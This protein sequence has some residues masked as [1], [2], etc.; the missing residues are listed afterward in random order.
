MNDKPI[1]IPLSL[2]QPHPQNPRLVARMFDGK[3]TARGRDVRREGGV[4]GRNH[5]R[6]LRRKHGR[7]GGVHGS[8][9]N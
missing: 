8:R 4:S 3:W 2:L 5:A 6:R 1:L 9:A 7:I